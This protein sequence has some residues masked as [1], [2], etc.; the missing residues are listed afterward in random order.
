M[1]EMDDKGLV[2]EPELY[3]RMF[4]NEDS[5]ATE[6]PT[7]R[8]EDLG[9]GTVRVR[10]ES[11]TEGSSVMYRVVSTGTRVTRRGR[12]QLYTD[13]ILLQRGQSL[14]AIATR[15]GFSDSTVLNVSP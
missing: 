6:Q 2:P 14:V 10:L 7:A 9:D 12:W 8:Q 11:S 13:P 5:A 15:L 3:R 4:D 1:V